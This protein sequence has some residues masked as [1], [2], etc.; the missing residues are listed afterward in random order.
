MKTVSKYFFLVMIALGMTIPGLA[1]QSVS[2]SY[3]QAEV[4]APYFVQP[5]EIYVASNGMY[6]SIDGEIIQINT[7]CADERGVFVPYEEIAGKLV[8]CPFCGRWYDEEKGHSNCPG[9]PE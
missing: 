5:G 9:F 7:L 6:A 8:R 3:S 4:D 1:A 2:L